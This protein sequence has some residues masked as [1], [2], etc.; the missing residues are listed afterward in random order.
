MSF[1]M[2]DKM[3]IGDIILVIFDILLFL[4]I[5]FV[6]FS[7]FWSVRLVRKR[8][9]KK[10][11]KFLVFSEAALIVV[12]LLQLWVVLYPPFVYYTWNKAVL[13]EFWRVVLGAIRYGYLGGV[14]VLMPV[15]IFTVGLVG[16]REGKNV[17]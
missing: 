2:E 12:G 5:C 6:A 11:L 7:C 13:S 8:G 17:E 3:D 9:Y 15:L 1:R 4:S 10:T 16:F 14:C